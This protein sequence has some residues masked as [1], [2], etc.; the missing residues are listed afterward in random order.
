MKLNLSAS[1][2]HWV[3][4]IQDPWGPESTSQPKA[5]RL[6][7]L[8]FQLDQN[9]TTILVC[10]YCNKFSCRIILILW[11]QSCATW[12][13]LRASEGPLILGRAPRVK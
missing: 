11:E 5:V 3:K 7:I 6:A 12:Y 10:L 13:T 2:T 1:W 8:A 4:Q 9:Q